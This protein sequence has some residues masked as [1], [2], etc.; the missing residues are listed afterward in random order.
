VIAGFVLSLALALLA[1]VDFR[2]GF[3]F[4]IY[5]ARSLFYAFNPWQLML[6]AAGLAGTFVC[7]RALRQRDATAGST[8]RDLKRLAFAI[9]ALLVVDLFTY[10]GVPAA[11]SVA[12]GRINV[13]WL[14]AFGV[15]AWWRP[16][17]Q[18]TSYLLN[19]WHATMIGY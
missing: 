12:S 9:L 6:F 2:R 19:V 10:R 15:T 14:N 8:A 5:P 7:H 3:L 4:A 17:A 1:L 18:A 16:L 13:D 11:R